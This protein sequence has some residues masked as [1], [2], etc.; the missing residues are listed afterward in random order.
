M[1]TFEHEPIEGLPER[2]PPGEYILWQGKPSWRNLARYTFR[3]WWISGYFA[4]FMLL[5]GVFAWSDGASLPSAIGAALVV[6]PLALLGAGI[7]ALMAWA[8]ARTTIYTLTNRRAVFR[9]GV[10]LPMM[11]NLP[12][13]KTVSAEFKERPNG[14]GDIPLKLTGGAG[15]SYVHLW[16]HVRPWRIARPEPMLKGIP[17][18]KAVARTLAEAL[19]AYHEE[20]PEAAASANPDRGEEAAPRSPTRADGGR[21]RLSP[22]KE[23]T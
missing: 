19:I 21:G 15:P 6:A 23:A 9:Y 2:L 13:D 11:V 5:R 3:I 14:E 4:F 8:H 18:V 7:L 20:R 16:P 12:F 1:M 10:A 22:L 17:E